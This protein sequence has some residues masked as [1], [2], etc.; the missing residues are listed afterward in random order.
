VIAA[1]LLPASLLAAPL[2][3]V[4]DAV[5]REWRVRD[6]ARAT[7]EGL[8]RLGAAL[9]ADAWRERDGALD[10][11]ARALDAGSLTAERAAALLAAV[12]ALAVD[13]GAPEQ[14]R[15]LTVLARWPT[16][17]GCGLATEELQ[18]VAAAGLPAVR[19]ALAELLGAHP[20]SGASGTRA[21][22]ERLLADGDERVRAAALDAWIP[23]V[24]DASR[25]TAVPDGAFDDLLRGLERRGAP[26]RALASLAASVGDDPAR[27]CL[28][29][30]LRTRLWG[31]GDPA[32]LAAGWSAVDEDW[33]ELLRRAARASRGTGP[34]L[35]AA[36]FARACERPAAE[37]PRATTWLLEG[38]VLAAEPNELLERA[39]SPGGLDGDGRRMLW[40]LLLGHVDTWDEARVRPWLADPDR[41]LR[42]RVVQTLAAEDAGDSDGAVGRLLVVALDDPEPQ[43]AG[44]AFRALAGARDPGPW[45]PALH[46]AWLRLP[47]AA[48]DDALAL[49]PRR[50]PPVAFRGDLLAL[51]RADGRRGD[52]LELLAACGPDAELARAV[53]ERL[54][55]EVAGLGPRPERAR[56]QACMGLARAL[57]QLAGAA[58]VPRLERLLQRAA[59]VSEDVAKN[60]AA[61][62]GRTPEGRRVLLGALHGELPARPR[63]EGALALATAGG[64]DAAAGVAVLASEYDGCDRDLRA[65]AIAACRGLAGAPSFELLQR[66]VFDSAEAEDL[67]DA[68]CRALAARGPAA[69]APLVRLAEGPQPLELRVTALRAL[70]TLGGDEAAAFLLARFVDFERRAAEAPLGEVE[71][72]E[73][74]VLLESLAGR[75]P[76]SAAVARAWLRLPRAEADA[77][78]AARFA[79]GKLGGTEFRWASELAL[80]GA[81][82]AHGELDTALAASGAWRRLDGRLLAALGRVALHEGSADSL[83]AARRLLDAALVALAG[84]GEAQDL[85]ALVLFARRDALAAAERAADWR[86]AALFAER[87]LAS[88]ARG[89]CSDLVWRSEFGP[90]DPARGLDPEARLRSFA[91]QA[92]ARLARERGDVE[93]A[94]ELLR[95]AAGATGF[96]RAAREAQERIEKDLAEH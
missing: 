15:A 22:L 50:V 44:V 18:A 6:W 35:G 30:A 90:F 17:D 79:G 86:A 33:R 75:H 62:L 12:R 64:E 28:V 4:P 41:D 2:Q 53:G 61:A 77:D 10:A 92:R 26:D 14:A 43:T 16:G 56:E 59:P 93:A 29:A 24:D 25:W 66:I 84:E 74:G 54:D 8:A 69:T 36:L 78:V 57:E 87:L 58:A 63:I 31:R 71:R 9:G 88:R 42:M 51:L 49:L 32:R 23:G 82:A 52:V 46:A 72:F 95:A 76:L 68:A 3:A 83:P 96:S 60:A 47:P 19:A 1:G 5:E 21:T 80:A 89:E 55:A 11:M 20:V 39:R 70:G 73:R 94:Q 37:A 85:P 27:A 81:I 38:A 34:A 45:L 65:R 40:E 91:L 13:V 67:R 48:R 7:D